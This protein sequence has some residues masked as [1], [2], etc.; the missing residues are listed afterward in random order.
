MRFSI[1]PALGYIGRE[2]LISAKAGLAPSV[3]AVPRSGTLAELCLVF[4]GFAAGAVLHSRKIRS[5]VGCDVV[6]R[7][8]ARF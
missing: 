4:F 2:L 3:V 7:R 5:D 1:G 6:I 8:N